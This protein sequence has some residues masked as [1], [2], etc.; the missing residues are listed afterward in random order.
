MP[1][2]KQVPWTEY[3]LVPVGVYDAEII[4]VEEIDS[5]FR[6]NEQLFQFHFRLDYQDGQGKQVV[7]KR[8]ISEK[9]NAKSKLF[10]LVSATDGEKPSKESYP[11]GISIPSLEGNKC[12]VVIGH[13]QSQ[14][15]NVW[16]RI[17][18]FLPLGS[19]SEPQGV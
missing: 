1:I 3:E 10:E 18:T 7:M 17:E 11:K 6:E 14:T 5:P 4:K 19:Q 9:L 15:G 2:T 8:L 16:A 13:T 12:R